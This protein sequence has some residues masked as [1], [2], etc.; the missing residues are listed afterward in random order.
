M[1]L[2]DVLVVIVLAPITIGPPARVVMIT[3]CNVVMQLMNNLVRDPKRNSRR[4][5]F[6]FWL[7]RSPRRTISAAM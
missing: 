3:L 7:R 2:R 4:L 1:I 6:D 5:R